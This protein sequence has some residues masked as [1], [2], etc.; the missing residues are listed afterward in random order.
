MNT[1]LLLIEVEPGWYTVRHLGL[2]GTRE[3]ER[4]KRGSLDQC[5]IGY[6]N[7]RRHLTCNI[8]K[9]ADVVQ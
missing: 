7:V 9:C 5:A 8:Q 6:N 3:I 4:T 1:R 2:S